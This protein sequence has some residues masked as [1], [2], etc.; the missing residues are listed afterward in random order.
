MSQGIRE[1]NDR[2]LNG[3]HSGK[4]TGVRLQRMS[5]GDI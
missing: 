1:K 3:I 2:I 4:F 5:N